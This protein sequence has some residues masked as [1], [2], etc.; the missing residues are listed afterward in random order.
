[1]PTDSGPS[2]ATSSRRNVLLTIQHGPQLLDFNLAESPHSASQAQAA[3]HGGTLPVHGPRADRGVPRIP[4]SGARSGP[5]PTST[6][7][8]W[9][10]ASC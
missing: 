1:M 9:S 2:T 4:I 6:R 8:A 7:S 3:M 5:R 10:S